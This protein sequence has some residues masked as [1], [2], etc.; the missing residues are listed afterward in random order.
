MMVAPSEWRVIPPNP[1]TLPGYVYV[2]APTYRPDIVAFN[3]LLDIGAAH[4]RAVAMRAAW[5][6]RQ[7]PKAARPLDLL[8]KGFE[9]L[10]VTGKRLTRAAVGSLPTSRPRRRVSRAER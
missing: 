3:D 7:S 9:S 2:R 10:R 6:K 5:C 8:S 4:R 1:G